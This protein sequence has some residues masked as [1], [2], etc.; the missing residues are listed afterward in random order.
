MVMVTRIVVLR[1]VV[2]FAAGAASGVAAYSGEPL[3]FLVAVVLFVAAVVATLG[4]RPLQALP[5]YLI[6]AGLAGMALGI[7]ISPGASYSI[8]TNGHS[9]VCSSTGGC[10][11]QTVTQSSIAVPALAVFTLLL[12]LGILWL[13]WQAFRSGDAGWPRSTR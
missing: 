11:G 2:W 4:R 12:L 10:V 3:A 5:A 8:G 6:G 9:A 1:F 7:G 13:G